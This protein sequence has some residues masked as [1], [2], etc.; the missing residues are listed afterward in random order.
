MIT[1]GLE[2]EMFRNLHKYFGG[3]NTLSTKRLDHVVGQMVAFGDYKCVQEYIRTS[4]EVE[5]FLF[6]TDEK[7]DSALNLAACEKYPAI[8]KLLLDNGTNTD[9]QN[10]AGRTPLME[11]AL[12]GRIENVKHL[13]KNGAKKD[14][15][16]SDGC[17][18]ADLADSSLK[19]D[20]ERFRRSGGEHQIYKEV[21]YLAN[22]ARRVIFE[23][24]KQPEASVGQQATTRDPTFQAHS[25]KRTSQGI[26]SLIGPL[27]DFPVPNGWKT[28]ATLQRPSPYPLVAAMSGW[29]HEE[30]KVTVSG[31]DWTDEVIRISAI[32]GHQLKVD[33]QRDRGNPGLFSAC[34]AE[35]QL[36]AYFISAHALIESEDHED[37]LDAKPPVPL[38]KATI[39]VSR[40]PCNDCLRF[41]AAVNSAMGLRIAVL[42]RSEGV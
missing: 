32:V 40:P 23:L 39:L 13:L 8:V 1:L 15:Y 38:R 33:N 26:I 20:E 42:D 29:S 28:I 19:N 4:P 7:G 14:L 25:F 9:H 24:L 5:L 3:E 17:Q 21:T 10:K 6:G 18:A 30:T 34:H 12:W 36:I 31:S 2:D 37:L 11:A 27:A 35:K 41:I 16:D 22:E